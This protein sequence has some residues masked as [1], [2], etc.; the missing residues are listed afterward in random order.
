[1]IQNF[2]VVDTSQLVKD[3]HDIFTTQ[4]VACFV[5][6]ETLHTMVANSPARK[7]ILSRIF[8]EKTRL[9]DDMAKER[10]MLKGDRCLPPRSPEMFDLMN[11][12]VFLVGPGTS[13]DLLLITSSFLFGRPFKSMWITEKKITE[14]PMVLYYSLRKMENEQ[15]IGRK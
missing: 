2:Q 7:N 4:R 15:L 1:M 10:A 11:S 13:M 5:R 14:Y 6:N 9:R 3:E 12:D 8:D